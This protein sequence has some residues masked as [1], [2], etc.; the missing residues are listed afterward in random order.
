MTDAPTPPTATEPAPAKQ[1]HWARIK[2]HM[3]HPE[4]SPAQVGWSLGLGLS[5]AFNPLLGLHLVMV[6]TLCFAFK[7]LHR[8]LML[9]A[10]FVNNPWSLVPVA[11]AST[12]LGN[13]LLGRGLDL[14]LGGV[15][16]KL[17]RWRS[18]TT[19]EGAAEV[20]AMLKPILL[21][22]LLGGFA[23]SLAAL[24]LGYFLMRRLTERLRARHAAHQAAHAA[25]HP[26]LPE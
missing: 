12:Y 26:P 5:I 24:V 11:T 13:V 18:F 23:I 25:A 14:D 17:I 21:P 10:S 7:G 6:L 20:A 16:W 15:D 9:A 8:P 2:A 3:L 22:Y 1:G 19:R 4:L